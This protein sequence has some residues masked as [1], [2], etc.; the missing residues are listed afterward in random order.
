MEEKKINTYTNTT[1][2]MQIHNRRQRAKIHQ[3]R[4]NTKN[5]LLLHFR[6]PSIMTRSIG[7]IT[8]NT[9]AP[10]ERLGLTNRKQSYPPTGTPPSPKYV[11]E[12]RSANSSS[13]LSST[14]KL[15]LCT[16]WSLMSDTVTPHWVVT[17]GKSWLAA[18]PHYRKTATWK[19]SM[20]LVLGVIVLESE[21]VLLAITR[22]TATR[23]TLWLDLVQE[24]T[25][26]M[27]NLAETR[28][29]SQVQIMNGRVL[30]PWGTY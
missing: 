23:A 21:L 7:A 5:V 29:T 25:L 1:R 20:P 24:A 4:E 15:T 26:I 19:E 10:V 18:R 22:T 27:E 11:S 28:P 6:P 3:F 12:W 13:S 16:H 8:M 30:K 2:Y 14:N 9:T 17:S